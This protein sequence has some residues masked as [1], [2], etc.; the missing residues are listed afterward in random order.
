MELLNCEDHGEYEV[1]QQEIMGRVFRFA[2]CPKCAEQQ[3]INEERIKEAAEKKRADGFKVSRRLC[4]GISKRNLYK[5]FDLYVADSEG[6]SKALATCKKYVEN[7]PNVNNLLMLGS[8]GTGKTLLASSIIEN[9]VDKHDCLIRKVVDIFRDIKATYSKDCEYTE[10]R[11][12]DQLVTIPLLMIDEI[13]IQFNSDTEK[14]LMFD[15]IDGRYQNMLPTI[16]I[17][18]LDVDGVT[19]I[20]GVRCMDRLREGGGSMIKFDW[21]SFRK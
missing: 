6:K 10:Q 12:I 2:K 18:N 14:L 1:K 4:A 8:V 7:F 20:V 11:V 3:R 13:G 17:S 16:L 19:E 9:L 5:G 21:E 15:I